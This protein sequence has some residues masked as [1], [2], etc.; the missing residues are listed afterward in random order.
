[1]ATY[2]KQVVFV[3]LLCGYFDAAY[4]GTKPRKA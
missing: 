3:L 4:L 1:M 2:G